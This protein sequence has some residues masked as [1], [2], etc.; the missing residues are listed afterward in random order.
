MDLRER[1]RTVVTGATAGTDPAHLASYV[2]D[3]PRGMILMGG[4]VPDDPDMLRSLTTAIRSVEAPAP[5][6]A[7]DQEGGDVSRLPWDEG[8]SALTLKDADPAAVE[9]AFADRAR[10]LTEAGATVNFGIV[11]DVPRGEGSFIYRRAFGTDPARAADLVA[12]AVTGHGEFAATLKHFPGHG[13]AEGDSHATIPETDMALDDWR[14][15]DAL[16]FAAGIDAGADLVMTGHLR[17]TA[18]D[19]APASLSPEWHR[20]LRD[21]LGFDGV[22]VTDDLGMLLSSGEDAYADPV[23]NAVHALDAGADLV[24]MIAGSDDET[25][26]RIVDGIVAAVEAGELDADRLRE[27]AER[28][29]ALRMGL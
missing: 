22:V 6:I 5:L 10:L 27:A 12:A 26:T 18:V 29:V 14:A 20:I 21:E 25:A 19:D 17:F 16:P 15:H 4:N 13:A 1:A 23:A 2:R 8:P 11:A 24:L 7:I 3:G 28:V 9:A